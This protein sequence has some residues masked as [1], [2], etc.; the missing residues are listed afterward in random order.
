MARPPCGGNG[1]LPDRAGAAGETWRRQLRPR[2]RRLEPQLA[3]QGDES[4]IGAEGAQFRVHLDLGQLLIV[5]P[6]RS[7]EPLAGTIRIPERRIDLSELVPR[8][9]FL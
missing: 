7:L 5:R 3:Q 8:E 1:R 2:A 6:K 4:R 9:S